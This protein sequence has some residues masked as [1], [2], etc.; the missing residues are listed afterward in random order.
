MALSDPFRNWDVVWAKSQ[1]NKVHSLGDLAPHSDIDC[2]APAQDDQGQYCQVESSAKHLCRPCNQ[3][4]F[5]QRI[6]VSDVHDHR[7]DGEVGMLRYGA[8]SLSVII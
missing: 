1:C 3:R 5:A 8:L 2:H 6:V 4:Y 7:A